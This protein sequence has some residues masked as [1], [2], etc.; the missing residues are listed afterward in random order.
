MVLAKDAFWVEK[1]FLIQ[2]VVQRTDFNVVLDANNENENPNGIYKLYFLE[3]LKLVSNNYFE[4]SVIRVS[5]GQGKVREF[6]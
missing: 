6:L 1:E 4:I 3:T 2:N 5:S